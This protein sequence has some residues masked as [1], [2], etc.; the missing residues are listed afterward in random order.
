MDTCI[1][2]ETEKRIEEILKYCTEAVQPSKK[3]GGKYII[4]YYVP[5]CKRK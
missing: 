4:H 3:D 5:Q 1:D 2:E